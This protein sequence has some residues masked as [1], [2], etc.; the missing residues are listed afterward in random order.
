[1]KTVA[2]VGFGYI[3]SVIGAVLASRGLT[4]RGI[5]MNADLVA[6]VNDGKCP[7]PEPGLE[8]L[9]ADGVAKGRLSASTDVAHVAGADVIIVTVGTPLSD[10]FD[11]DLSHI[12]AACTG[13]AEHVSDGQIIMVK[14]TVPPGV[15]RL[16]AEEVLLPKARVHMAF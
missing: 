7:L 16:M 9:I 8:E 4:V 2:V 10:D 6:A 14:S 3:G 15:T 13:I 11:A 12:R 1:M 5:D